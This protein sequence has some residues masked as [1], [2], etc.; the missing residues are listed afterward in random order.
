MKQ[1]IS[2]ILA[3]ILLTSCG[4][5]S[6]TGASIPIE[7]KTVS[8]S[9]FTSTATNSPSS[10][11]QTITEGLKDL[12]LSQTSLAL[13]ETE[14]D[15]IFSGEITKYHII[16]MAIQAN[17]TAGQNRLTI[18]VKVMYQNSYDSKQNFE[19]NFS[20][21]RDFNSSENLADI[22]TAL[23]EEITAEI[24]EDVFNKAFVNW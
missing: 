13:T 5:Y 3:G 6:F 17:E 16:P 15:L 21:Y 2:I 24:I 20:R 12:F 7:A 14:G 23:I 4:I 18:I 22:E 10:L 1:T 8:V 11:N 9:Y 19:S